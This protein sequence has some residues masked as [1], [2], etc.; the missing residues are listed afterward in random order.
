MLVALAHVMDVNGTI[1]PSLLHRCNV[2]HGSV[3]Q[4]LHESDGGSEVA[5]EYLQ[6]SSSLQ[7]LSQWNT[8]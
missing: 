4:C 5:G 2:N 1:L 8:G 3:H 7:R 6:R